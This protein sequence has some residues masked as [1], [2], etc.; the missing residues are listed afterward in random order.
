MPEP[1]TPPPETTETPA[2]PGA[3]VDPFRAYNFRLE[4]QGE[5][6]GYFTECSGLGARIEA[7]QFREGGAGRHVHRLP[8]RVEYADVTLR[9]GLTTTSRLWEW[10]LAVADG[11]PERKNVS[12]IMLDNEG[13]EEVM[14]WDL[15][16]AFPTE[17]RGAPLDALGQEVAIESLT[18]VFNTLERG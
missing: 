6:E 9:Y 1:A 4:F 8:G 11:R 13:R 12:I 17:W 18:L 2:Q 3:Y 16:D 14:R 7:L 10:F 15:I 5:I